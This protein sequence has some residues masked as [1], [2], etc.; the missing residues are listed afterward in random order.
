MVCVTP[1]LMTSKHSNRCPHSPIFFMFL[2]YFAVFAVFA[3][4][5]VFAVLD[6]CVPPVPLSAVAR[7][8]CFPAAVP[9]QR[10]RTW[11]TWPVCRS[12]APSPSAPPAHRGHPPDLDTHPGSHPK[13]SGRLKT[14][15]VLL[16]YNHNLVQIVLFAALEHHFFHRGQSCLSLP[17]FNLRPTSNVPL[18]ILLSARRAYQGGRSIFLPG[19]GRLPH[20]HPEVRSS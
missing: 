20:P 18:S 7:G 5:A 6:P 4:F 15:D 11:R 2:L 3:I 8:C 9:G 13:Q 1:T 12:S 16:H 14:S 17:A 19:T 10:I